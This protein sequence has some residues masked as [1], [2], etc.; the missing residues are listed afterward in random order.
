MKQNR[1]TEWKEWEEDEEKQEVEESKKR[2]W[3]TRVKKNMQEKKNR[4]KAESLI[5]ERRSWNIY[6]V[7]TT[8]LNTWMV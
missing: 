1:K 6:I 2:G 8:C 3:E 7:Y 5:E 4:G